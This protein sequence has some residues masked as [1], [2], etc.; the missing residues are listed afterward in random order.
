[1]P[2]LLEMLEAA[3]AES[4]WF[5]SHVSELREEYGG[6]IVAVHDQDVVVSGESYETVVEQLEE[7]Q[8]DLAEALV[9]PVQKQGTHVIR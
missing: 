5:S 1:M 6:K 4:E 2:T 9:R 8:I 7:L 3:E